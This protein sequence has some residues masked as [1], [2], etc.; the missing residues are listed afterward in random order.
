[1]GLTNRCFVAV[2]HLT[3]DPRLKASTGFMIK[4]ECSSKGMEAPWRPSARG[5]QWRPAHGALPCV[6][7]PLQDELNFLSALVQVWY[8][9]WD[10][11]RSK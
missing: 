5:C 7:L 1:M 4:V 10:R 8:Q 6:H 2:V 3:H 9:E 11:G